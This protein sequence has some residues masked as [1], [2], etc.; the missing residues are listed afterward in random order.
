MKIEA[1]LYENLFVNE[2]P[3]AC[4]DGKTFLDNI[5][6]DSLKIVEAIA[7]INLKD[8]K[9]G[10]QFQFERVGY[11][12]IDPD[13]TDEKIVVNRIVTLKDKWARMQKSQ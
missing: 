1:R 5:N 10:T 13:S 3:Y 6:P 12:C 4:E 7:E 9:S 8:L 2:D 11:F